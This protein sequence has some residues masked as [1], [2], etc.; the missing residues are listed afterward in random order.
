MHNRKQKLQLYC[1][2]LLILLSFA[3]FTYGFIL[4][5]KGSHKLVDP[6]ANSSSNNV[7]I[8]PS[9]GNEVVSESSPIDSSNNSSAVTDEST[10]SSDVNNTNSGSGKQNTSVPSTNS[11]ANNSNGNSNNNNGGGNSNVTPVQPS[12]IDINN[13]FR[14]QIE[15]TYGVVV[16]YGQETAGYTVGG[17]STTQLTDSNKITNALNDLNYALSLYPSGLFAEIRNGGIP[18]TI[19][20]VE[21]YSEPNV[22]GVTDSDY[23]SATIS[24]ATAFPFGESFYHESYHYIERYMFKKGASFATWDFF[25]PAGFSYGNI[26]NDYSYSNTFSETA[27]FVNNYAQTDVGED[28]ASTFEYMMASSKASCLNYGTPVWKKANMMAENMDLVLNTVRPD[29]TEY[30]ERYLH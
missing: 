30:W 10:N 18:L 12:V 26:R 11:S 1:A 23:S 2:K 9:N 17:L 21:S 24:I 28:R 22:T 16:M 13:N 3:F 4:D 19:V 5:L 20:L 25:N 14:R 7:S 6:V 8:T 29:V 27:P 15:G